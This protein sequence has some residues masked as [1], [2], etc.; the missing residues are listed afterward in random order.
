MTGRSRLRITVLTLGSRG[1]V[2]PYLG[3]G[4][5]LV[6]AGHQ[7]TVA[8]PAAFEALI[9][10]AEGRLPIPRGSLPSERP[11]PAIDEALND[12]RIAERAALLGSQIR[13]E[14]GLSTAVRLI[15]ATSLS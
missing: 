9:R 6:R 11:V 1:D 10:R 4:V 2:E 7:I 14:T 13:A 12:S 5:A 15:E 3:L 8:A